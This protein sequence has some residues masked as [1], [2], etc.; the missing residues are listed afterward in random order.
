MQPTPILIEILK[1]DQRYVERKLAEIEDN[2]WGT[3]RLMW[4]NRIEAI[5]Q[6]I[7]EL[8]IIS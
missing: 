1:E 8:G 3:A 5:K 2:P 6:Q 7:A 4:E